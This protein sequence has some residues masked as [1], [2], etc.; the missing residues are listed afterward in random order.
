MCGYQNSSVSRLLE[1][2]FNLL[3]ICCS[4]YKQRYYIGFPGYLTVLLASDFYSI[5]LC[6]GIALKTELSCTFPIEFYS[7]TWIRGMIHS[8]AIPREQAC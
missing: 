7:R 1:Y 5:F 4:T 2:L 3:E 8:T 6:R